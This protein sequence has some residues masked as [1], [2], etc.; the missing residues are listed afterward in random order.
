[1]FI[2]FG[3]FQ[4]VKRMHSVLYFFTCAQNKRFYSKE[5]TKKFNFCKKKVTKRMQQ[6]SACLQKQFPGIWT[7][8]KFLAAAS[9][10]DVERLLFDY[11]CGKNSTRETF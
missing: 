9:D 5:A 3:Y 1:M 10:I 2:S 6:F 8:E 7:T 11:G 4:K